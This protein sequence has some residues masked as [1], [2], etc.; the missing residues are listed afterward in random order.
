MAKQKIKVN[1]TTQNKVVSDFINRFEKEVKVISNKYIRKAKTIKKAGAKVDVN[2]MINLQKEFDA[3]LTKYKIKEGDRDRDFEAAIERLTQEV[4]RTLTGIYTDGTKQSPFKARSQEIKAAIMQG[5][6]AQLDPGDNVPAYLKGDIRLKLRPGDDPIQKGNGS[7][8][9]YV[10]VQL[11]K[12][13]GSIHFN[14][15][16]NIEWAKKQSFGNSLPPN[17]DSVLEAAQVSAIKASREMRGNKEN[18]E[19]NVRTMANE[20]IK[21][22]DLAEGVPYIVIEI[23][24]FTIFDGDH[25][26]E[27]GVSISINKKHFA[28]FMVEAY[29]VGCVSFYQGKIN[30]NTMTPVVLNTIGKKFKDDTDEEIMFRTYKKGLE[31]HWNR[32]LKDVIWRLAAGDNGIIVYHV[33]PHAFYNSRGYIHNSDGNM[34]PKHP[35]SSE[36]SQEQVYKYNSNVRS[37]PAFDVIH[38]SI[39]HGE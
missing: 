17:F 5:T 3:L 2:L 37:E 12:L 34:R 15:Y 9:M 18:E 10:E 7:T 36:Y 16:Y 33:I 28:S 6:L 32:A 24:P 14:T 26:T 39:F 31:L 20:Y 19:N 13:S 23:P 22:L 38:R 27:S 8:S 4:I 29:R 1:E 11:K 30:L 25:P 35:K 21:L